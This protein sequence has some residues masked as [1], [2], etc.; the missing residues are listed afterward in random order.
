MPRKKSIDPC[1]EAKH[2]SVSARLISVYHCVH[3]KVHAGMP[4]QHSLTYVCRPKAIREA[5]P[6][7]SDFYVHTKGY[8]GNPPTIMKE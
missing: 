7:F 8:A 1:M 3:D 5:T 6:M 4:C 2:Y